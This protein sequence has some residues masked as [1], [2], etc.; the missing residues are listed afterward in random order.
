MNCALLA[1]SVGL[2]VC[3]AVT[4]NS[5]NSL[6][7]LF[8]NIDCMCSLRGMNWNSLS[9]SQLQPSKPVSGRSLTAEARVRNLTSLFDICAGQSD[10]G[11][12]LAQSASV[13]AG[14]YLCSNVP[15]FINRVLTGRRSGR[16]EGSSNEAVL[17]QTLWTRG[18][19]A[20]WQCGAFRQIRIG[21]NFRKFN[22]LKH[23]RG[24]HVVWGGRG[25]GSFW[26]K[27]SSTCAKWIAS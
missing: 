5:G 12:R 14:Q 19:Q 17:L 8:C 24:S 3:S 18:G 25:G 11:T 2:S 16:N 1:H 7:V 10:S 26:Y 27:N 4:A 6:R 23:S 13:F 22:F 15:S 20:V 21:W 9:L